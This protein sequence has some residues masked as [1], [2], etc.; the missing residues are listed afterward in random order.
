MKF[1]AGVPGVS[2]FPTIT[3]PWMKAMAAPDYQR[4]CCALED[5]GFDSID[6]PE[7]LAIDARLVASMGAYWPHAATAMAFFAGATQR[8]R[9]N[10]CVI[11]LPLHHPIGLAKSLST[12]DVLSGGR[13]TFTVGLGHGE[14]EFRAFGVPFHQRGRIADEYL[15]AIQILWTHDA[16]EFR[17]RHVAFDGIAFE[18]KPLQRPVPVWIGGNVDAA[19]RR[20]VRFG[21]GWRPSVVGLEELPAYQEKIARF[22]EERGREAQVELHIPS[23]PVTM[24]LDHSIVDAPP[25]GT[26]ELVDRIGKLAALGVGW[27]SLPAIKAASLDE[28]LDRL[29]NEHGPILAQCR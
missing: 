20:A 11:M 29:A 5:I 26:A 10:A 24:R 21:T 28:Y 13:V 14:G 18:P 23:G 12:L 4:V 6:C 19:I 15:E 3:D 7:H 8:I 17:G 22:A 9:V 27:T 25:P 1:V 2:H 16:P